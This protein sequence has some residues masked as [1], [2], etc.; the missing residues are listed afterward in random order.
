LNLDSRT[1]KRKV[2]LRFQVQGSDTNW[3]TV[4]RILIIEDEVPLAEALKY[5]LQKEGY[6]VAIANDGAEG[7]ERFSRDGADLLILDLMLPS[8]DGLEVCRRVRQA[9]AVPI[10]ML[11][12]KDSEMDEILG[13]EMGADDYVTKPFNMRTLI[14][15]VKTVLRR[16]RA[17]AARGGEEAIRW[18]EIIMDREKHEVSVRGKPV[19]LTPTEYRLLE[20]LLMRPGKALTRQKIME[21]VWV[22]FYGSGKTLDVHVR[23]LREKIEADPAHPVYVTTVRGTG[24]RLDAPDRERASA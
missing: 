20:F 4:K 10:I 18:G 13:L 23:H 12:A 3:R 6:E 8:M 2:P 15:R 5:T 14:T 19:Q 24:Y 17:V 11:T 16:S 9:S 1:R 21:E 22:D 7:L